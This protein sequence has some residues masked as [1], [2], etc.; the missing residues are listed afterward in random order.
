MERKNPRCTE[1]RI[2]LRPCV[3]FSCLSQKNDRR[4]FLE[5]LKSCANDRTL[6]RVYLRFCVPLTVVQAYHLLRGT[7]IDSGVL[8]L[9]HIYV[10]IHR[11]CIYTRARAEVY[12]RATCCSAIFT[13]LSASSTK[14]DTYCKSLPQESPCISGSIPDL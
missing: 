12:I 4:R 6:H 1:I 2:F 10:R 9:S 14:T 8:D 13:E 5:P 11:G 3:K 7:R